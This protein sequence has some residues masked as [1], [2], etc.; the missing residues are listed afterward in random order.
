MLP[1]KKVCT[2]APEHLHLLPSIL[3]AHTLA[4]IISLCHSKPSYRMPPWI[5]DICLKRKLHLPLYTTTHTP[6]C[7]CGQQVNPFG[8]HV[9]QCTQICKIGVHK[10]IRDS[11][12]PI[13]YPA[14]STTG[15]LLPTSNF[16]VEPM[17][18]LP[19]DP[20]TCPF[21]ISFNP[22]PALPPMSLMH[23]LTQQ[24]ALTSPSAVHLHD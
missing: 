18:Y 8:D 11:L 3:S 14:L 24:L 2:N 9:F 21:D 20:N 19:L 5:F 4:P 6:F 22:D 1:L 23:A 17:L 12:R 15:Y 10:S 7:P 16:E 13:L